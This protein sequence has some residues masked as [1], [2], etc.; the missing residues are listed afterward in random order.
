MFLAFFRH[1]ANQ[2]AENAH[3][4]SFMPF[5][6]ASE[7]VFS[8]SANMGN[9]TL[10]NPINRLPKR[11]AAHLHDRPPTKK[12]PRSYVPSPRSKTNSRGFFHFPLQRFSLSAG[13]KNDRKK[14]RQDIRSFLIRNIQ[15]VSK[16]SA[17]FLSAGSEACKSHLPVCSQIFGHIVPL[18]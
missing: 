13:R 7:F 16:I 18:L 8:L 11:S 12:T 14:C 17:H 5:F 3:I 9:R 10:H 1:L 6:R 15:S 4:P 2:K